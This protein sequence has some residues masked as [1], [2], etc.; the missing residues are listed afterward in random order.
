MNTCD[1]ANAIAEAVVNELN[2]GTYNN[3][4]DAIFCEI[5]SYTMYYDYQWE[6][7][8]TYCNPCDADYNYALNC[9]YS[10]IYDLIE[11]DEK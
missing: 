6:V 10:D 1:L 7:L 9:L 11:E 2:K 5:D 3:L 8:K 4:T